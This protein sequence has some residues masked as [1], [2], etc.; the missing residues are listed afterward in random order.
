V[1]ILLIK[2]LLIPALLAAV[3]LVGRRFGPGVAGW[4]GSFPVVA[5]PVLL[6]IT[7]EQGGPFGAVAAEFALAG[8]AAAMVFCIA[9]ARLSAGRSWWPAAMA[10]FACWAAAVGLLYLLPAGLVVSAGVGFGALL[11]APRFLPDPATLAATRRA[12]RFELPARM[13]VGALLAVVSSWLAAR[14]GARLGG[15]LALFPLVTSVIAVFT[16]AFDGREAAV[17]F[18]GGRARGLWSAAVFCAVLALALG[19]S[20]IAPAFVVATVA[21]TVMHALLRP[22][23]AAVR[24]GL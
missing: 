18:L 12:H 24:A 20:G 5:G 2:L 15:Y 23:H 3:T 11:V 1:P 9:Y 13:L 19:R 7:L 16:H 10:A 4:L 22:R 21:T 14:F 6:V 8:M 17:A